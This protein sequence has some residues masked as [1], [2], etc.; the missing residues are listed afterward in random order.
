MN[1]LKD[2]GK[3]RHKTRLE[4]KTPHPHPYSSVLIPGS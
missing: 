3:I 2:N 4:S 1:L